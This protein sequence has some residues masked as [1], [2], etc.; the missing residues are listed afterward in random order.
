MKITLCIP[1]LPCLNK[2]LLL[3]M[4]FSSHFE[5]KQIRKVLR[6]SFRDPWTLPPPLIP[7]TSS[8]HVGCYLTIP[9][10]EGKD[11]C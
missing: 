5:I 4:M 8:L 2:V 3:L 7:G 9:S 1:S 6:F 11:K 10:G